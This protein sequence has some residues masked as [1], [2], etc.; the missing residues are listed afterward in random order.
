MLKLLLF[1][2]A[3]NLALLGLIL[4]RRL[5]KPV[6]FL[7]RESREQLW[8]SRIHKALTNSAAVEWRQK[9]R[10][11]I[12]R[13]AAENVLL[14]RSLV[15]PPEEQTRLRRLFH[16]WQLCA[17][18]Q[19][20]L[21]SRD[22]L[23]AAESALVLG[24]MSCTDSLPDLLRR[25]ERSKGDTQVAV[26]NAIGL[27]GNIEAVDRLV[28]FLAHRGATRSQLVKFALVSCGATNPN[29]LARRLQHSSPEVRRVV[30]SALAELAPPTVVPELV[31]AANDPHPEVRAEVG[32]A[33]G[34]IGTTA[35]MVA[36]HGLLT[37]LK[38]HVRIRTLEALAHTSGVPSPWLFDALKDSESAVRLLAAQSLVSCYPE[39]VELLDQVGALGDR[40][41][42]DAIINA[43]ERS[44]Y[45]WQALQDLTSLDSARQQ[46]SEALV[47]RLASVGVLNYAVSAAEIH[48]DHSVRQK[49]VQLLA[50]QAP[51][52][53]THGGTSN[54]SSRRNQQWIS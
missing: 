34:R 18:R 30:A 23:K 54:V 45:T 41:A 13:V 27:L 20:G 24:R 51:K 21:T 31:Q 40:A 29:R 53:P 14:N 9:P 38:A 48:P 1:A 50:R 15:A 7:Y 12:D 19:R 17:W 32:Y 3:L 46:E 33:L 22:P 37:D 44:G 11:W 49:L 6:W 5:L 28:S 36:L 16:A 35:A 10:S 4:L 47:K 25:L 52:S 26:L 8:A 2:I 39:P 43:L 42:L